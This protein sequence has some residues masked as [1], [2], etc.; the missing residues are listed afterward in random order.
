MKKTLRSGS[1]L[2][3]G[4]V[5]RAE[6]LKLKQKSAALFPD[7]DALHEE[8]R[9]GKFVSYGIDKARVIFLFIMNR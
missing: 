3:H 6:I 5:A 2:G 4:Y 8:F 9:R 1:G 7:A